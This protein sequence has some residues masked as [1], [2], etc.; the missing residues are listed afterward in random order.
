MLTKPSRSRCWRATA[1][2]VTVPLEIGADT[3]ITEIHP[4]ATGQ[5]TRDVRSPGEVAD[6]DLCASGSQCRGPFV[7]PYDQRA[8]RHTALAK[9]LDDG[10]THSTNPSCGTSYKDRAVR[11]HVSA[12]DICGRREIE[13]CLREVPDFVAPAQATTQGF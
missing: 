11:R 13:L 2:A 5:S 9:Q 6:N 7:F 10:T 3:L 8:D 12:S 1:A 4:P